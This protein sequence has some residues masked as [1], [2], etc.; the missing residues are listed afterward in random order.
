MSENESI[1]KMGMAKTVQIWWGGKLVELVSD[2]EARK[3]LADG[4]AKQIATNMVK[5]TPRW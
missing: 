2:V 3:I 5:I 1:N 4:N